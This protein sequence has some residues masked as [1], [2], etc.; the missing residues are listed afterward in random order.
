MNFN[1]NKLINN[2]LAEYYNTF[3]QTLDTG[4]FVPPK[5]NAKIYKY[6]YKNLKEKFKEIEI[7]NLLY[8]QDND[9]KLSIFNKINIYFSGLKPLYLKEQKLLLKEEILKKRKKNKRIIK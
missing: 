4:D 2:V 9:Y 1:K 8:L 3:S 5:F 7:Y 6:I